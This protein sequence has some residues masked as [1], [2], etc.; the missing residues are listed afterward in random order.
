MNKALMIVNMGGPDNLESIPEYLRSIFRDPRILNLPAVLRYPIA[1]LITGLRSKRVIEKYKLI[2][3]ASPLKWRTSSLALSMLSVLRDDTEKFE[4]VSFAFRY[5][6]PTIGGK[7]KALKAVGIEKILLFPMFPHYT[8]S[9]TGSI[10]AKAEEAAAE[11]GIDVSVIP[12]WGQNKSIISIQQKYLKEAIEKVGCNARVLFVAHGIP[13]SHV[14]RGEDYPGQVEESVAAISKMLK[15]DTVRS[16]AYQSK[17]GPVKWTGPYLDKELDR[18]CQSKD[19]LIIMPLSF[20]SDCLETL[21]DLDIV[22]AEKIKNSGVK[23]FVRVPVFNDDTRF[24]R[25][26]TKIAV[27]YDEN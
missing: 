21:Y 24:A 12:E 27:D 23:E 14:E 13:M 6:S 22:A 11:S 19:P 26:L 10:Q 25:A 4:T 18:L 8:D 2:G 17:V 1:S 7:M 15:K 16:L 20:V 3:S 9:M 5:T